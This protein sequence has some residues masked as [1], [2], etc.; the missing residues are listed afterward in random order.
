MKLRMIMPFIFLFSLLAV[1]GWE[2]FYSHPRELPS[3]L[4]G[5]EL[6]VFSLPSI[7]PSQAPLQS[8]A[9][10]E[11]ILLLNVFASWCESCNI[12]HKMLMKIYRDYHVKIFG[13][14]YKD[15][16]DNVMAFLKKNGNPYL[17]IG[18]DKLGDVAIDLGVYG[19]PETFVIRDGKIIYRYI[20]VLDQQ[21]WDER[22]YPLIR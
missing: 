15:T 21:A 6:P 12:E 18:D 13:I 19:T 17:A 4:I 11:K 2:L 20:G 1:L 14:A 7:F 22:I 10:K 16:P 3:A 5:Q 9:L 8:D